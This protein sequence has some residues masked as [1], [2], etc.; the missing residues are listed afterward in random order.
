[1]SGKT[2]SVHTLQLLAGKCV[3]FRLA[4][5]DS[6]LFTN[7]I[8]LAIGK[9][10]QSSKPVRISPSLRAEIQH[11]A[12]PLVVAR[13]RRVD[14]YVDNQAVVQVWQSQAAWTSCFSDALKELSNT[15]LSLNLHLSILYIP[16]RENPLTTLLG[17][18][19]Q[20]IADWLSTRGFDFRIIHLLVA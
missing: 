6:R 5:Q 7:E 20:R 12:D 15:V 17:D 16:S 11:W 2:V 1:L 18:Y 10:L 8:N 4:V 3:S 13:V 9:D 14:A 19:L